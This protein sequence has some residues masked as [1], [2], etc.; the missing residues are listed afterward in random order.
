MR[1]ARH[2]GHRETPPSACPL[3]GCGCQFSD[4]LALRICRA[5]EEFTEPAPAPHHGRTAFLTLLVRHHR[6]FLGRG[7]RR[8]VLQ[9][10]WQRFRIAAFGISR[11]RQ[12]WPAPA[13]ADQHRRTALL[14]LDVRLDR[15]RLLDDRDLAFGVARERF[16]V[17]A[18]RIARTRQEFAALAGLDD[19]GRIALLTLDACLFFFHGYD[20][21]VFVAFEVLGV[22]AFGIGTARQKFT[23]FA[24]AD[25]QH[26]TAKFALEVR[27]DGLRPH[28]LHVFGRGLQ[29]RLE[30]LVELPE[31]V[32][33][34]DLA[35][36]DLVEQLLHLR[37]KLYIEQLR[38]MFHQ[39]VSGDFA[40]LRRREPAL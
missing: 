12:E 19:H 1:R 5:A 29:R 4:V 20:A 17:L 9:V 11:A 23:V 35:L 22:L 24:R 27:R 39:D 14:A 31:H 34:F 7:W 18:F 28:V 26:L 2:A 16:R 40:E 38:E 21:P 13:V 32:A 25:H 36:F 8:L 37:G 15:L 33:P 3:R 6:L 30:V 10:V